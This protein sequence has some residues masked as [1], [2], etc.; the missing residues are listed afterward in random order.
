VEAL[1]DTTDY[2]VQAVGD[3]AGNGSFAVGDRRN[4]GNRIAF[5]Y[6]HD[7]DVGVIQAIT[8]GVLKRPLLMNPSGGD[9]MVSSGSWADGCMRMGDY[10]LWVDSA[11][12]VRIKDGAPSGDT[13]GAVVGS[14]S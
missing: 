9:V 3:S 14:Q 4:R 11:G 1:G 6:D 7:N 10:R 12:R 5:G 13:D 8:A 2:L